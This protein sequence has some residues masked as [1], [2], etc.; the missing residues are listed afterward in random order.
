M[1]KD[2]KGGLSA[3][4]GFGAAKTEGEEEKSEDKPAV[5]S[6]DDNFEMD[7]G[8]PCYWLALNGRDQKHWYAQEVYSTNQLGQR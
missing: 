6:D 2:K 3:F 4:A 5:D 7:E 1:G 8:L